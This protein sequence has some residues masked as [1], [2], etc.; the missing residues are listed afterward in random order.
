MAWVSFHFLEMEAD[1]TT[2]FNSTLSLHCGCRGGAWRGLGLASALAGSAVVETLT[3]NMYFQLLYRI[4]LHL[5][6]RGGWSAGGSRPQNSALWMSL[7]RALLK[8]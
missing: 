2:K 8:G 5:K 1:I 7:N 6:V 4:S 3:V